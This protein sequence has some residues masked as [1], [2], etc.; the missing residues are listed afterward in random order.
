MSKDEAVYKLNSANLSEKSGKL[1]LKIKK[2]YEKNTKMCRQYYKE[3]KEKILKMAQDQC[4]ALFEEGEEKK[5]MEE[6]DIG[7]RLRKT[8]IN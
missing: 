1:S 3:S 5:N 4:N 2:C 8:N 6:K 7:I